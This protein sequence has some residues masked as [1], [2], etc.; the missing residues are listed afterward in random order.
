MSTTT[1]TTPLASRIDLDRKAVR[2]GGLNPTLL[3]LEAMRVLRNR[4]TLVFTVLMP[5]VFYLIFGTN[6][7]Y[8]SIKDGIGTVGGNIMVTM[9]LYGAVM[10]A[11]GAGTSVSIERATG[12]SR[13][14]R[15]T[16]LNPLAYILAKAA[17]GMILAALAVAAVL[18]V[19]AA[20]GVSL[21]LHVWVESGLIAWAGSVVFMVFGLFV[22]YL[23]PTDNAMQ[24]V[25][26][27]M[28]V[29]AAAGGMFM[30][31]EAGST[32]DLFARWTPLYGLHKLV[33]AP[34][35]NGSFSWVAVAN[36][37][38][39]GALFVVGAAWR[40]SKDTARV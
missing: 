17:A 7:E 26:P 22:G 3:R 23:L 5:V 12:W 11:T 38:V 32:L 37:V 19:G 15:L 21:P 31:I 24:V 16:P 27:A 28:A 36:V 8:T 39:W 20:T 4:R 29:L 10:A 14:L 13:Q 1:V 35:E 18:A 30:P 25:G 6:S 33:L 9:A 40:M 34:F 2:A